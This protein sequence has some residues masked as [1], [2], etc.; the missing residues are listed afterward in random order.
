MEILLEILPW[1]LFVLFWAWIA[2]LRVKRRTGIDNDS[3]QIRDALETM[4]TRLTLM[5][6][7]LDFTDELLS[8]GRPSD[9]SESAREPGA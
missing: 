5:E 3:H 9:E 8:P 7:R 2:R 4:D 6:E 1:A